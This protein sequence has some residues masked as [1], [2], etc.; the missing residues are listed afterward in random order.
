MIVQIKNDNTQYIYTPDAS[1]D[2]LD[3]AKALGLTL[4]DRKSVV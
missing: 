3:V 1:R 2:Y 4:A